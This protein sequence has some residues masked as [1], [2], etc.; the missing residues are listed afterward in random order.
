MSP[1]HSESP[2][3]LNSPGLL[4]RICH[5]PVAI[6]AAKTDSDGKAVHGECYLLEINHEISIDGHRNGQGRPSAVIAK[7]LSN[8]HDP[9]KIID[10]AK[11]L[12]KALDGETTLNKIENQKADG[13]NKVDGEVPTVTLSGVV[14]KIVKSVGSEAE[15]AEIAIQGAEDLYKE[16]R[17]DNALVNASGET[18][19]MKPGTEVDVT[20]VARDTPAKKPPELDDRG[21]EK[22]A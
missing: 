2:E 3:P 20:I 1:H 14:Q 17:I 15:K 13:E 16:I 11:E 4:C 12:T 9:A 19:P 10:F 5:K 22:S 6:D 7:E 8:E 21:E 18:V